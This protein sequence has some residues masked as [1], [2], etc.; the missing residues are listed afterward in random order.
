[1]LDA[2]REEMRC[3]IDD[4]S[5]TLLISN[6]KMAEV[7]MEV[8]IS[9]LFGYMHALTLHTVPGTHDGRWLATRAYYEA[10]DARC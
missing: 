8:K 3:V 2:V 9:I 5:S 6:F 4:I 10:H 1:M 7:L